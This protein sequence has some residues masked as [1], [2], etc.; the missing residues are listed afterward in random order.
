MC[1]TPNLKTQFPFSQASIYNVRGLQ[2]N[3]RESGKSLARTQHGKQYDRRT[4]Q[5]SCIQGA[6]LWTTSAQ[7]KKTVVT[8][9]K[10][11]G[12]R[13]T[14]RAKSVQPRRWYSCQASCKHF[15][16]NPRVQLA[17]QM[18]LTQVSNSILAILPLQL[19][20]ASAASSH[21]KQH[22]IIQ[23]QSFPIAARDWLQLS[24]T[25]PPLQSRG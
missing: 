21:Q 12:S 9:C 17:K 23:H 25:H 13:C 1:Q 18:T 19:C 5:P 22:R 4:L 6:C 16:A 8:W 3:A 24:H 11:S 10:K 7:K 2:G 14:K 20:N 15:R